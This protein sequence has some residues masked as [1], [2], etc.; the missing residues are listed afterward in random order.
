M[1]GLA[2]LFPELNVKG[3]ELLIFAVPKAK[4][5]AVLWN[6]D[7]PSHAPSLK[8]LEEAARASQLQLHA[9]GARSEAD[10]ESAFSTIARGHAQ[11]VLVLAF[12]P[13]PP[14]ASEWPSW[15]LDSGYRRFS[16]SGSTSRWVGSSREI[17]S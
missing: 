17:A 16:S 14:R 2:V 11:A 12:A 1:T 5:I 10:L 4:R 13:T 6:P 7:T 9:V 15:P 3:V 8:A